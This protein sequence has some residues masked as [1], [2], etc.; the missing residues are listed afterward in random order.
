MDEPHKPYGH[1]AMEAPNGVKQASENEMEAVGIDRLRAIA[2][3]LVNHAGF[4]DKRI[5]ITRNGNEVAALI[6]LRD[7]ERLRELDKTAA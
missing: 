4:G 6:G 2:G 1:E 7:L 3:Q 5:P